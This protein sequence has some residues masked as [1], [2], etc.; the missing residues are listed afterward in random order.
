MK[1]EIQSIGPVF[2]IY[3]KSIFDKLVIKSLQVKVVKKKNDNFKL[4]KLWRF[5]C[6]FAFLNS[7]HSNAVFQLC[8]I[9]M[10]CIESF[11]T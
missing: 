4:S 9:R 10:F 11:V 6:L 8:S 7:W 1:N 5:F 3:K 2:E